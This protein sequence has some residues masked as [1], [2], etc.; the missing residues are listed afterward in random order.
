MELKKKDQ[1]EYLDSSCLIKTS[2]LWFLLI[3]FNG[4]RLISNFQLLL[5]SLTRYT[6]VLIETNPVINTINN[7]KRLINEQKVRVTDESLT[8]TTTTTMKK[9]MKMKTVNCSRY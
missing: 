5:L 1:F 9:K 6:L 4:N 7:V 8:V 2:L 3:A